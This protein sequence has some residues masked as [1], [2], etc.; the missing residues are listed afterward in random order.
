M[1]DITVI[2]EKRVKEKKPTPPHAEK[3]YEAEFLSLHLILIEGL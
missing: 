2:T 3:K 1:S